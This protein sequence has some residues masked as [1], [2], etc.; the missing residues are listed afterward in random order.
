MPWRAIAAVTILTP[1][2]HTRE[3]IPKSQEHKP[4]D[5]VSYSLAHLSYPNQDTA[6][7][8]CYR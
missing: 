7:L 4:N 6:P 8:Y 2:L 1:I 5:I 3:I